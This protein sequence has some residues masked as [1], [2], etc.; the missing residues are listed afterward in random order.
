MRDLF[1]H[2]VA[3]LGTEHRFT[4]ADHPQTN[5]TER[6]SWT[7]RRAARA[8]VGEKLHGTHLCLSCCQHLR[9]LRSQTVCDAIWTGGGDSV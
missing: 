8:Y 3:A 2:V 7:L 6:V 5:V 9:E 4:A 1:E